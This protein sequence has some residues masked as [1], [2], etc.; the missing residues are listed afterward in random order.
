MPD[1]D[2]AAIR[3]TFDADENAA[4][5]ERA[6]PIALNDDDI[7]EAIVQVFI[8]HLALINSNYPSTI[9]LSVRA[10]SLCEIIDDDGKFSEVL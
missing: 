10:T 2:N 5:N 8:V 7:N 6:A 9:D 4:N 1:F 3:I